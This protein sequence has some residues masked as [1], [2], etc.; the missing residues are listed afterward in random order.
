MSLRKRLALLALAALAECLYFPINREMSGGVALK[1]ALDN[2]VPTIAYFALPYL[3]CLPF[4]VVCLFWAA[5]KMEDRLYRQLVFAVV[6][7]CLTSSVIYIVFPTYVIRP[8]LNGSG[9]AIQ[10]ESFIFRHDNVYNAFPSGH[11]YTTT[12]IAIFWSRWHPNL[13]WVLSGIVLLV[14]LSTLFTRQH[15]L[16]D[17]FGGAALAWIGYEIGVWVD[18]KLYAGPPALAVNNEC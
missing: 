6:F 8:Q 10:L 17:P 7:V 14:A 5:W 12:L 1:T 2:F 13:R 16:L 15:Y 9:W 3:L 18:R 11:V 4:W